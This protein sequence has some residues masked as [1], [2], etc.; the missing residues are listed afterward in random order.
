MRYHGDRSVSLVTPA[1]VTRT[2]A[3]TFRERLDVTARY[4]DDD[5]QYSAVLS[6]VRNRETYVLTRSRAKHSRLCIDAVDLRRRS[7][8]DV[9]QRLRHRKTQPCHT[10]KCPPHA[11]MFHPEG[12]RDK[13]VSL[14]TLPITR[15]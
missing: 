6:L 4:V 1:T 10:D 2:P 14:D 12:G 5:W 8:S 9:S 15:G 7:T 3:R 13:L 11:P